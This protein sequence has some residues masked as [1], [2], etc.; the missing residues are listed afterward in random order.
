[1]AT[2]EHLDVTGTAEFSHAQVT[3]S[4]ER[5]THQIEDLVHDDPPAKAREITIMMTTTSMTGR[6]NTSPIPTYQLEQRTKIGMQILT[7]LNPL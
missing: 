4:L 6:M 5:D 3:G 1:M 2:R 7:E